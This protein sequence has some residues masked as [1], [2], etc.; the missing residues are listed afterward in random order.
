MGLKGQVLLLNANYEALKVVSMERAIQLMLRD[1]NPGRVELS[2]GNVLHS[3][4]GMEI[5]EPSILVLTHYKA[6][7]EN[8]RKSN[9]GRLKVFTRYGFKC[10]YCGKKTPQ[11]QL[12]L[13]HVIPQSRGGQTVPENLASSCKK[14]NNRKANR[15]PQEAGMR[16]LLKPKALNIGVTRVLSHS[17][18]LTRPEWKPYLYL[19]EKGDERFQHIGD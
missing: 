18:A 15:T 9:I 14:C 19:G 8:I 13:D 6:V 1:D 12:T 7:R 17:Y 2:T 4:G 10:G 5:P 11:R 3:A 16:L